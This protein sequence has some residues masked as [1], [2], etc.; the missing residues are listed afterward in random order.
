MDLIRGQVHSG[1]FS[2][3]T[4][5]VLRGAG[6]D[7][8]KLLMDNEATKDNFIKYS[9]LYSIIHV[10]AHSIINEKIPLSPGIVFSKGINNDA[11]LNTFE[12][13]NLDLNTDLITLSACET[14]LGQGISNVEGEGVNGIARAFLYAGAH[15]LVVSLWQVSDESSSFFMKDFYSYLKNEDLGKAEALRQAKLNLMKMKRK[16][17]SLTISYSHPFFWAPFIVIGRSQ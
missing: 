3:Y 16:I 1:I 11:I 5:I 15:S 13:Y 4:R 14:A 17:G 12:I 8:P 6:H 7:D 10:S 9:P 2:H